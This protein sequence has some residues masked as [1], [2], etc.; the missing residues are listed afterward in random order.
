MPDISLT[1][2]ISAFIAGFLT[3][4]APCTLP[5]IPAYI[6]FISGVRESKLRLENDNFMLKRKV[7]ANAGAFVLGFSF[8]FIMF[9]VLAG[10]VGSYVGTY[11]LLFS[12]VGGVL[13]IVFGF[14]MLNV[15]SLRL[16]TRVTDFGFVRH[17]APGKK[18]GAFLL[19][20]TFA[21][22]WTPCVGPVLAT[23]LLFASLSGTLF[24]GV[25]L[26]TVFSL[27][28]AIPFMLT[29]LLFTKMSNAIESYG[30]IT[31]WISMCGGLFMIFIGLLLVTNSSELLLQY[32][33]VL[34][35]VLNMHWLTA[36]Y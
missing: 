25:F 8:I 31:K 13:I 19:G 29:A 36:F 4:L 23:I 18:V 30:Y 11:K 35:D 1:F 2:I 9:G 14:C 12:Q 20:C 21:L 22:G 27:G 24:Y 16:F 33:S 3:F 34:F 26:L 5:M 7:L 28:L 15:I 17:I 6:A 10:L 32:G